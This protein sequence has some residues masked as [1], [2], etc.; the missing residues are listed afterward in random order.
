MSQACTYLLGLAFLF[1]SC[2]ARIRTKI[3]ESTTRESTK[4]DLSEFHDRSWQVLSRGP[5]GD[6]IARSCRHMGPDL[7]VKTRGEDRI[8]NCYSRSLFWAP[9]ALSIH[10]C[11]PE[12]KQKQP[13]N[14]KTISETLSLPVA[15]ILSPVA[16]Q[17]PTKLMINYA[18]ARNYCKIN[19]ENIISCN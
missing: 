14:R 6:R 13:Q 15:K 18:P 17:A 10:D 19:S 4:D 11:M 1:W 7:T 3:P 12:N 8:A 9:G 16:R 5:S 2:G